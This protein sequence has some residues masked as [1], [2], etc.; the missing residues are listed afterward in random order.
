MEQNENK[1][2][3]EFMPTCM[4]VSTLLHRTATKRTHLPSSQDMSVPSPEIPLGALGAGGED[5]T[6]YKGQIKPW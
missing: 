6:L 5:R 2:N 4:G 3:W 1:M